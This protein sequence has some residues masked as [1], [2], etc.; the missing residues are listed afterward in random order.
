MDQT[1]LKEMIQQI[2]W[3]DLNVLMGKAT[4]IPRALLELTSPDKKTRESAYWKIDNHVVVQSDLFEAA[5]YVVPLLLEILS[6]EGIDG[7]DLI[8]DLLYEIGNGAGF[9][10]SI[11]RYFDGKEMD[12][13]QACRSEVSQG[14]DLY[15]R[16]LGD[17]LPIVRLRLIDLLESLEEHRNIIYPK[18]QAALASE[19]DDKVRA[20]LTEAIDEANQ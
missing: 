2:P 20:R 15:L 12:L 16:D 5:Y 6:H 3:G 19:Q 8:Y 13:E 9:G 7:R 10:K 17:P 18:L 14:L 4:H 1:R 11:V